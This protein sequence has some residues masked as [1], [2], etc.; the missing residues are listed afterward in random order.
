MS[1]GESND[2]AGHTPAL[3]TEPVVSI[4]MVLK[5]EIELLKADLDVTCKNRLQSAR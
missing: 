2:T 3:Q 5:T 1:A 4:G